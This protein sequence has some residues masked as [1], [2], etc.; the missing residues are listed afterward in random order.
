[1]VLLAA[2]ATVGFAV[3]WGVYAASTD[4]SGLWAVGLVLLLAGV[5][6]GLVV[7]LTVAERVLRLPAASPGALQLAPDAG[8]EQ[9]YVDRSRRVDLDQRA[10]AEW[11]DLVAQS[12]SSS[13]RSSRCLGSRCRVA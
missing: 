10:D 1:M 9:P 12:S 4:D 3:P 11:G 5:L 13:R 7:V 6:I 8:G 2:A